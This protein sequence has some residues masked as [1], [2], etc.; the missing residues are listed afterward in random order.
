MLLFGV[1]GF[2]VYLYL[3]L[4]HLANPPIDYVRDYFPQIDLTSWAGFKWM[5]TGQMFSQLYFIIPP[6]SWPAEI[7]RF[8]NQFLGNYHLLGISIG[9]IGFIMGFR[10]HLRLQIALTGMFVCHLLFYLPYGAG[11]KAWMFSVTYVVWAIWFGLGLHYLGNFIRLRCRNELRVLPH[12]LP[13]FL[14]SS[15]V[16]CNLPCLNL[17]SDD[18]ARKRAE[19]VFQCLEPNSYI[20]D[21]WE[22]EPVYEYL[23]VVEG[24]RP[25]LH[26]VNWVLLEN[27]EK[28]RLVD[29]AVKGDISL[30]TSTASILQGRK[31]AVNKLANGY[32]YKVGCPYGKTL[33]K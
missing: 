26:I 21:G 16:A 30:Y 19:M 13:L 1:L 4:R 32:L 8:V 3:P 12:A 2:S 18:T 5:V 25:D 31:C 15:L 33:V 27:N 9:V 20:A 6:S 28:S 17:S 10:T 14:I 7:A 24:C 23:H 11:D 29:R 22:E